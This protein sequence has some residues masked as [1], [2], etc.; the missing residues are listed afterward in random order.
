MDR[1]P[2]GGEGT[3]EATRGAAG[4][5]PVLS[6]RTPIS[7]S[8]DVGEGPSEQPAHGHLVFCRCQRGGDLRIGPLLAQQPADFRTPT[9]STV[10][11]LACLSVRA[12]LTLPYLLLWVLCSAPAV[13][14]LGGVYMGDKTEETAGPTE[15]SKSRSKSVQG[16]GLSH[17]GVALTRVG[18][19]EHSPPVTH[20]PGR[21]AWLCRFS[22]P[23]ATPP[24]SG[25]HTPDTPGAARD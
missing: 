6:A 21:S 12:S 9:G 10:S 19:A 14:P 4:M 7:N 22:R 16:K 3:A 11:Q 2:S 23:G 18:C 5:T 8:T 15:G 24:W 20:C 25:A 17:E 1:T 13:I